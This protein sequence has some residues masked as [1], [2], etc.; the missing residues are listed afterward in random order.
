MSGG[1]FDYLDLKIKDMIE[2]VGIKRSKE[3]L[4][5]AEFMKQVV[6]LVHSIEWAYSGDTGIDDFKKDWNKFKKKWMKGGQNDKDK[7]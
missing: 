4:E 5:F 2:E 6:F 3:E 1:H 7:M